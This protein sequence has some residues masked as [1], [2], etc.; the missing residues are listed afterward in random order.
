MHSASAAKRRSLAVWSLSGGT[1]VVVVVFANIGPKFLGH[2]G[3]HVESDLGA[4]SLAYISEAAV[5]M[6]VIG[7]IGDRGGGQG[8][9]DFGVVELLPSRVGVRDENPADGM[10]GTAPETSMTGL[11]IAGVLAKDRG[12]DGA[13]HK[14]FDSTI[15]VSSS[16]AFCVALKALATTL[17]FC[18]VVSDGTLSASSS[19][20]KLG[21]AQKI[22]SLKVPFLP[23]SGFLACGA[24]G[25][26][27]CCDVVFG[28]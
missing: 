22:R 26:G 19:V 12:E 2:V 9:A 16:I 10:S 6:R 13:D 28:C 17:N 18:F 5:T 15:A 3:T 8:A 4:P 20:R 7:V 14:V 24:S 25:G 21:S 27:D 23:S 1:G 11:K